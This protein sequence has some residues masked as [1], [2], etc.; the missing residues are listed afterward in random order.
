MDSKQTIAQL[1]GYL[2]CFMYAFTIRL[3]T[4]DY[5]NFLRSLNLLLWKLTT[6]NPT[7][8]GFLIINS[9]QV[10]FGMMLICAVL[11]NQIEV[12]CF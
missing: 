3:I 11:L 7:T 10:Q 9:Q 1:L 12:H 6:N 5:F 8:T 2:P 4:A